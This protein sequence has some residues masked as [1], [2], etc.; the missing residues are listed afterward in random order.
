[1]RKFNPK[2]IPRPNATTLTWVDITKNSEVD[3]EIGAGAGLHAIRYSAQN[4][5]RTMV[6]IERTLK[7]EKLKSRLKNHPQ[8]NN[9]Y[10]VRADAVNWC[11]Q[12]VPAK[13]LSRIFILYPNPYPKGRQ[14]N[15]RW[16]FMPFMGFLLERLK[17]GGQL[18]LATNDYSYAQDT[19][20]Q[21]ESTWN[22]DV[23]EFSQL[24]PQA[25]PRTHFEKKYLSRNE[26]CW[27]LIVK[28]KNQ[29]QVSEKHIIT[30][31]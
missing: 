25:N 21:F 29:Q 12:N 15:L 19:K 24:S 10:W 7:I 16:A 5:Q 13:S 8:I 14:K 22:M 23:V 18:E 9:L 31:I 2:F 1:M 4:P 20:A 26:T 28:A 27:N 17:P 3:L 6:A 30:S 11:V